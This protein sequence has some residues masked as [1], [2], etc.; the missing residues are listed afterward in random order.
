MRGVH[1]LKIPIGD[2]RSSSSRNASTGRI[3]NTPTTIFHTTPFFR[4]RRSKVI[5][6]PASATNANIRFTT[7]QRLPVAVGTGSSTKL[8]TEF[9]VENTSAEEDT[10]TDVPLPALLE[11]ADWEGTT[12]TTLG[13]T[14][15]LLEDA[16][17]AGPGLTGA[18]VL[19]ELPELEELPEL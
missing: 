13:R 10:G 8:T 12:A 15:E 3:P 14:T 6:E 4:K 19:L 11:D 2:L 1:E 9:S 18:V 17:A 5:I 7:L 16:G